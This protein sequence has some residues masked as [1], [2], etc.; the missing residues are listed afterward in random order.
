MV[1]DG[2]AGSQ[3]QETWQWAAWFQISYQLA[4]HVVITLP[5]Y[6]MMLKVVCFTDA[7]SHHVIL[8]TT[9]MTVKALCSLGNSDYSYTKHAMPY[10]CSQTVDCNQMSESLSITSWL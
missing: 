9:E 2:I 8:W 1:A 10:A 4:V 7:L 3:T 5:K 6:I